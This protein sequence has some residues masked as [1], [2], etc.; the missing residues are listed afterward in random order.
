MRS[1]TVI[2]LQILAMTLSAFAHPPLPYVG[3][4]V[5]VSAMEEDPWVSPG[6]DAMPA[7]K[8]YPAMSLQL[9]G[10]TALNFCNVY[11]GFRQDIAGKSNGNS[12]IR[13][14][15]RN[16]YHEVYRLTAE[17]FLL[18][19]R[20]HVSDE[21]AN[22]VKPLIGGAISYGWAQRR[23]EFQSGDMAGQVSSESSKGAFG[24]LAEI[25]CLVKTKKPMYL[26]FML[27]GETLNTQFG[28]QSHSGS[29]KN[30]YQFGVQAGVVYQF[31][32]GWWR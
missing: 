32:R 10:G 16:D 19:A 8:V 27:R 13:D 11:L 1:C 22:P 7:T 4:A 24:W 17:R 29:I 15:Y 20:I 18:G 26:T 25:G 30:V 12:R 2:L 28:D 21:Y 9:E 23:H 3:A 5:Q 14:Y 31:R 6:T